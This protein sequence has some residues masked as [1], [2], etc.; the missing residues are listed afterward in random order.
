MP[1]LTDRDW[2]NA[3]CAVDPGACNSSG[4]IISLAEVL[5][6]VREEMAL[7]QKLYSTDDLNRHPVIRLYLEQLFQLSGGGDLA[8]SDAYEEAKKYTP[9][10]PLLTAP[11]G[12]HT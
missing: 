3:R 4:L 1:G 2:W 10:W 7:R 5:P 8:F 11:E 12:A 6:R 9:Y